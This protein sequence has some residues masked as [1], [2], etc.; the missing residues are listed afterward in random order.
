M[1]RVARIPITNLYADGAYTGHI[2]IG[3][4]RKP[5][6]LLLDSGSSVL[7]VDG[8]KYRPS[9]GDR[10]SKFAQYMGYADGSHWA[11]GVIKTT[12]AVGGEQSRIAAEGIN[13]ALAYEETAKMFGKTDGILGLAYAPLDE[14]WEMEK[15]TTAHHYAGTHIRSGRYTRITP[16]LTQLAS[17][18]VVSDKFAFYTRRSEIHRGNSVEDPLNHGWMIL[19]GGEQ[20]REFY[21]GRFQAAR[22]ISEQWYNTNLK[23]VVVGDSE[24]LA[25][26]QRP[27]HGYPSNSIVDSG[28]NSLDIGPALLKAMLSRFTPAQQTLLH[29]AL[30]KKNR[31]VAMNA[32]RLRTWPDLT[33][34]L[35]GLG[36]KDIV[37]SVSPH[38]YWQ[39]NAPRP[40]LAKLAITVGEPGFT[41]LGLPLMNG[42]F[43]IFDGDAD[44]GRG[45]VKFAP[46]KR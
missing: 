9:V 26:H 40:G 33:I 22:V 19:G 11:G 3:P 1:P 20:C 5:M 41:I 31:P 44:N 12:V 45:V 32:L 38:D 27:P 21:E 29:A 6:N 30:G 42:Y 37:L 34:I 15:D 39:V 43:T 2:L 7:A 13:L 4:E 14:A 16:Y 28:T 35:E 25:L 8:R 46:S 18:D 36:R 24:P 23:A 17:H 10:T